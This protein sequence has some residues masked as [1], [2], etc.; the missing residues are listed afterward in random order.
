MA[1]YHLN[2]NIISRARGQSVVAA[3]AYRAGVRLRDERYGLVHNYV[4]RRADAHVEIMAPSGAPDWAYD[5]ELLWNRVESAERRKDS[6][7]ARVIEISLPLELDPTQGLHL[8]RDYVTTAFVARGMIADFCI[9]RSH[10]HNPHAQIM[11]TLRGVTEHGFGPKQRQWNGKANLLEWR[12]LWAERANQHLAG[13]GVAAR[14][15]HRTLEAQQIE[16]TPSRRV[17][18][19]R[20]PAS[21]S[22]LPDHLVERLSEQRRIARANGEAILDDP[23]LAVRAL[24]LSSPVFFESDL[25]RFLSSRTADDDQFMTV[26]EAVKR[27]AELVSIADVAGYTSRDM[28]EASK[29]L[30][31]RAASMAARRTHGITSHN[32]DAA[33][34][35]FQLND[36]M[37]PLFEYLVEAGAAK[38]LALAGDAAAARVRD[39]AAAAW[40]SDGLQVVQLTPRTLDTGGGMPQ[41]ANQPLTATSVLVIGDAEMIGA[42]Q[43]ERVFAAAD[44]VRAKVVLIGNAVRLDA[45]D[46]HTPF[47]GVQQ[48][49]GWSP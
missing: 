44:R 11:L 35:R 42:K 41:Q 8:I 6:Q 17:G 27:S 49:T 28:I 13:A 14:I 31:R 34:T 21:G 15:D 22:N 2:A 23:T 12:A 25:K 48:A 4:G 36:A 30:L 7:L 39:A 19:G 1:I 37:R 40:S 26:L 33:L 5:R 16:L 32:R 45:M 10:S 3:A 46:K 24:A 9:R 38:A 29:S 18:V 20:T 43:L 47:R